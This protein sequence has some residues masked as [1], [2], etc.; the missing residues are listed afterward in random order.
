MLNAKIIN[1]S[2]SADDFNAIVQT[3]EKEAIAQE[4]LCH[5]LSHDIFCTKYIMADS[6][7]AE[8]W[9]PGTC[10]KTIYPM[11]TNISIIE[12]KA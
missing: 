4:S 11:G 9:Y 1:I 5:R 7:I 12:R 10:L 3:Y 6:S 8:V 2:V